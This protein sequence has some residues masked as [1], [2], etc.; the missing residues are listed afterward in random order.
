MRSVTGVVFL[1]SWALWVGGTVAILL[2]VQR[3]FSDDRNL[4]VM[5]APKMFHIFE[6]YQIILAA[7]SIVSLVLL[8][9]QRH[10]SLI[11]CLILAA[12]SIAVISI[13]VITPKLEHFRLASEQ[14]TSAFRAIHGL[15]MMIY[16]IQVLAL[17]AIGALIQRL[18]VVEETTAGKSDLSFQPQSILRVHGDGS[19][20]RE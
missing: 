1:I 14:H 11:W 12:V 3:L 20:S 17:L 18:P 2:F 4:A 13:S 19:S 15:S 8:G 5:V 16:L 6:A 9:R 7:A 10:R